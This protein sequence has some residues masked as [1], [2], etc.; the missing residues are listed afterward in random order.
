[1]VESKLVRVNEVPMASIRL[2]S[3]DPP[4][5]ISSVGEESSKL[6]DEFLP[7]KPSHLAPFLQDKIERCKDCGL[8]AETSTLLRVKKSGEGKGVKIVE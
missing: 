5:K 7:P 8:K 1:M 4:S 6:S 3:S 2:P